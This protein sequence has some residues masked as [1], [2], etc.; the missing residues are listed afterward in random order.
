MPAPPPD[1]Q[2]ELPGRLYDVHGPGLYRYALM[3]LT[4][5]TAAEDAVQD[6]FAGLLAARIAPEHVERYLRT[7][8]R[9]ACFTWLRRR[10]R[11]LPRE[12]PLL[13]A[14]GP[15]QAARDDKRLAIE[16]ALRVLPPEQ[17]EVVYLHVFEGRTFREIADLS[18][19]S[20]NTAASRYRY[21]L[22]RLRET[23]S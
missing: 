20:I 19:T 6:A 18:G 13:E 8:V 2:A 4:Y 3:L 15:A 22:A 10:R 17:R 7:S 14:A 23:L 11:W 5:P 21:A 12:Q 1:D 16:R 9:N